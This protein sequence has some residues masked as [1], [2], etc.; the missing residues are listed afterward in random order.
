MTGI[1]R[2]GLGCALA[3][4]L[5]TTLAGCSPAKEKAP[6]SPVLATVNGSPVTVQQFKDKTELINLGFSGFSAAATRAGD[7]R[8]DLLGQLIEEAM[9]LQEARRLNISVTDAEVDARL[10]K[11]MADYPGVGFEKV[12]ARDGLD[13]ARYKEDLAG[14]LTVEKLIQAEVYSKI[15]VTESQT[16]SYYREHRREF[17]QPERVR[18]RQ[19]VVDNPKE[20]ASILKEIKKGADFARLARTR[21]LS[22][23]SLAGGD[24]GYFGRGE[25]PPEFEAAVFKMKPG[26]VSPVVKTPYGYH[27]F[28]LEGV[29]KAKSPTLKEAEAEVRRRLLLELGEDAFN[30]WR[31]ALKDKTAIKVNMDNIGRL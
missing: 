30:K 5:A 16:A 11:V 14:R 18:A 27:I 2:A 1:G 25:M 20:A 6:A 28:K 9:Y 3:A 29:Q 10:R 19:I 13:L 8:M 26:E 23:D 15:A 7:A 22:P 24:L 17:C 21:S 12:L 4:V 31:E